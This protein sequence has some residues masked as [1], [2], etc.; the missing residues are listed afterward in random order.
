MSSVGQYPESG[1]IDT[2]LRL[3]HVARQ[4]NVLLDQD[5]RLDLLETRRHVF[6]GDLL[7]W[8]DNRFRPL[9]LGLSYV[10]TVSQAELYERFQ[11]FATGNLVT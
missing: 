10:P 2:T 8:I 5:E 9:G 11:D 7:R 1:A 6:D 3:C 4:M